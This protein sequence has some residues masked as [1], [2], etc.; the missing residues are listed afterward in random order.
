MQCVLGMTQESSVLKKGCLEGHDVHPDL[1]LLLLKSIPSRPLC[2]ASSDT[3]AGRTR[4]VLGG[5]SLPLCL[6]IEG[7]TGHL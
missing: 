1:G 2:Q 6:L 7:R 3:G 4:E 5:P